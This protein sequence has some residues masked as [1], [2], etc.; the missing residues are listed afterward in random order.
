M[1]PPSR[2]A[3]NCRQEGCNGLYPPDE[4]QRAPIARRRGTEAKQHILEVLTCASW[5]AS[6]DTWP[7]GADKWNA[8]PDSLNGTFKDRSK[9]SRASEERPSCL[10]HGNESVRGGKPKHDR[11]ER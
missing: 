6:V 4:V 8:K 1:I 7:L 10:F 11:P 2:T 3:K 5:A 9:P